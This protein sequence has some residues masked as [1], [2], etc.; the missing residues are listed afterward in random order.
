MHDERKPV[1][2]IGEREL[3]MGMRLIGFEETF[4]STG[5][6]GARDLGKLVES[7]KYS[8]ILAS[9]ELR[10]HLSTQSRTTLERTLE[11]LVV[12]LPTPGSEEEGG[13]S[14]N[15]LAKRV[16]GISIDNLSSTSMVH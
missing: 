8:M 6:Q 5:V 16:L 3:A 12:F 7:G 9:Q 4:I 11:P 15:A 2:V 13:E 14:V 1:A 10:R